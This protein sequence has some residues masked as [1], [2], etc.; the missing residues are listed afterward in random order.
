[1]W[2][3]FEKLRNR[4]NGQLEL[5]FIFDKKGHT[6]EPIYEEKELSEFDKNLK[7]ALDYNPKNNN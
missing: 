3:Q 4:E 6:K 2:N 5:P 1:M 7:K